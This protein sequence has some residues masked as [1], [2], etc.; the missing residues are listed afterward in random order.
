[1]QIYI[2][3]LYLALAGGEKNEKPKDREIVIKGRNK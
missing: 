1:M 3:E 2:I